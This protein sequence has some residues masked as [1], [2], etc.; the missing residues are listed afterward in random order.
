[1][2][3][4]TKAEEQIMHIIWQREKCL[5]RDIIDELGEPDFPHS[6]VSSVMCILE[7]KGFVGHKAYGKTHEHF[8]LIQ[9]E[10][11]TK[12]GPKDWI[13]NYFNGSPQRLIS[14][15]VEENQ[16]ISRTLIN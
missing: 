2:Q 15:L 7:K 11:Y 1:M 13:G 10:Q 14:F 8:P 16:W 4:L 12:R 9:K 5:V 3:H 6:T